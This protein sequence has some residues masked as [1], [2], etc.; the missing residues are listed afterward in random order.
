MSFYSS[1]LKVLN[2]PE[3][4]TP[5]NRCKRHCAFLNQTAK[6]P[7]GK[8]KENMVLKSGK[9]VK[10]SHSIFG[11]KWKVTWVHLDETTLKYFP[12]VV[13]QQVF[14]GAKSKVL[15]LEDYTVSMI[16]EIQS[17][18]KHCFQLVSK[19]KHKSKIFACSSDRECR[20]WVEAITHPH[21]SVS[22]QFDEERTHE[23]DT[24]QIKRAKG[25]FSQGSSEEFA[26]IQQA[27]DPQLIGKIPRVLF[28][29][30][31]RAHFSAPEP[32]PPA[33]TPA[34]VQATPL[35]TDWNGL[36]WE[37]LH[38]QSSG[39]SQGL[40]VAHLMKEFHLAATSLARS[41]IEEVLLHPA[42]SSAV[43]PPSPQH[44][45]LGYMDCPMFP[46][47][48]LCAFI[49][50]P[51]T[52]LVTKT[53]GHDV[54]SARVF[55]VAVDAVG[56][57]AITVP[58]QCLIDYLGVRVLVVADLASTEPFEMNRNGAVSSAIRQ[59][60][61]YLHT[62]IS[63]DSLDVTLPP[64]THV[65]K[66]N[67]RIIVT[68][69]RHLCAPDVLQ[70]HDDEAALCAWKLRPE[71]IR[72]YHTPLYSNAYRGNYGKSHDN[73]VACASHYLQKSII[74]ACVQRLE[75]NPHLFDSGALTALMHREGINMRYI[76][77]MYE[78]TNVK[79]VRRFLLTEMIARAAK[80]LFRAMIREGPAHSRAIAVDF[81][82]VLCG[83][84]KESIEFYAN[85]IEPTVDLKF[86]AHIKDCRQ[87]L[88][89]PQL[90]V[91][92][93]YHTG[94]YFVHS[95]LYAL[96]QIAHPFRASHIQSLE[97]SVTM[98]CS[99]TP[100]C[101]L[102]IDSI[103]SDDNEDLESKLQNA[104][105]ALAIEQACPTNV[106][107]VHLCNLLVQAAELSL[108]L[109]NKGDAETFATLALE[110]GPSTHAVLARAHVVLMNLHHEHQD[111]QSLLESFE[112][113]VEVVSWHLSATHPCMLDAYTTMAD[114]WIQRSEWEKALDNLDLSTAVFMI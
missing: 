32:P 54:R 76:G 52:N 19:H 24:L 55:Q 57:D 3:V 38:N 4:E 42:S 91:A 13:N 40:S 66:S 11:S 53:L 46:S 92:L 8:D 30:W 51:A 75:S 17:H 21:A 100:K 90:F 28:L 36:Y 78:M 34:P 70:E 74:P 62:C 22:N 106:R 85:E 45:N 67:D 105:L 98:L 2:W 82:N 96:G 79:Y 49:Y 114:I 103:D 73:V 29:S 68:K 59:V 87:E 65:V 84:S 104:K 101:Q 16:D 25:A 9:L 10:H 63:D 35:A 112:K 48:G 102:T 81:F 44:I 5:P 7:I 27:L 109:N 26:V 93:Q 80:V 23:E 83:A 88:H 97:P 43:D 37:L 107:H 89:I 111:L 6:N 56:T 1:F 50:L 41:V 113:A 31:A 15:R 14:Q 108:R 71:Y 61:E 94:V 77:R 18:R 95:I 86:G 47:N 72:K 33:P 64:E 69:L 60:L 12:M 99:T 58:L 39:V 110:E 20:E